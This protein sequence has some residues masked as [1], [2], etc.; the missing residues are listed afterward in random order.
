MLNGCFC[1]LLKQNIYAMRKY[2]SFTQVYGARAYLRMWQANVSYHVDRC[3][4][5]LMSVQWLD[6]R[7]QYLRTL[8]MNCEGEYL[9]NES[10]EPCATISDSSMP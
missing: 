9:R 7:R 1:C 4:I 8:E 3:P 2:F 5:L 6:S 10:T